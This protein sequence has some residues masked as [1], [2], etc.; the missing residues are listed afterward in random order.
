[1]FS[2]FP[3][4]QSDDKGTVKI[5]CRLYYCRYASTDKASSLQTEQLGGNENFHNV[6]ISIRATK[7]LFVFFGEVKTKQN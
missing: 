4:E 7:G 2:T 5:C 1:M 6:Y 3:T